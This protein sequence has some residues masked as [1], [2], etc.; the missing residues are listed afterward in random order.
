MSR[1]LGIGGR[2]RMRSLGRDYEWVLEK[3]CSDRER[4]GGVLVYIMDVDAVAFVGVAWMA[5]GMH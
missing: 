2:L 4:G 5:L 3:G 1:R